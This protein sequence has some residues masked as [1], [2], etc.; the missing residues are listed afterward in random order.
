MLY[1]QTSVFVHLSRLHSW[2]R[3]LKPAFLM[4]ENADH[5]VAEG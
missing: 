1:S 2:H 4:P 3:L 5:V